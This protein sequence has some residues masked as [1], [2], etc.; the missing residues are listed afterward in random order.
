MPLLLELFKGTGSFG[1]VAK[2][3][4]WKVI[5]LDNEEKFNPDILTDILK[6]DY[7]ALNLKPDYISASPPCDTFTNLALTKSHKQTHPARDRNVPSMKALAP[8]AI[9]GDKILRKTIEIINYYRR[10]NPKLKFVMENPRGSMWKSPIMKALQPYHTTTTLY[11]HYK[12]ERR[13]PTDFFSNVD[14]ILKEGNCESRRGV[15]T[16][17]LCD[18]YKIPSLLIK[19]IFNQLEKSKYPYKK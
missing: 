8:S 4:G 10:K 16:M 7:K 2:S 9:L 5:S 3:K 15:L 11:C 1:K 18:R 14:L 12:D 17:P 13:K 6:W 19:S